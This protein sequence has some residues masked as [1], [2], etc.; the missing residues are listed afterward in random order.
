[1]ILTLFPITAPIQNMVRLG[2]TDIPLWQILT[3]IGLLLFSIAL[4]LYLSIKIFRIYMLMHG[5]R[6]G[7]K[8]IM[9]HFKRA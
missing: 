7:L 1:M 2:V 4:G 8:T 6:P 9:H 3:S 5:K